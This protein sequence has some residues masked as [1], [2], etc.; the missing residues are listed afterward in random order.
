MS[1]TDA[2]TRLVEA[3]GGSDL[4]EIP[5][6]TSEPRTAAAALSPKYGAVP[7]QTDG[8]VRWGESSGASK[9]IVGSVKGWWAGL[10]FKMKLVVGAVGAAATIAIIAGIAAGAS[11]KSA[12]V[13]DGCT[14]SGY[15]LSGAAVPSAYNI[16]WRTALASGPLDFY[17]ST[18]IDT[19]ITASGQNCVQ[20]HSYELDIAS[21]TIDDGSGSG[22]VPA[23]SWSQ[24]EVNER[25]VVR[26]PRTANTGA[27]LRMQLNYSAPLRVDNSGL[28]LTTYVD[29][30]GN[31]VNA[32]CTQFEATAFRRASPGFDEPAMKVRRLQA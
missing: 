13:E 17:G 5:I 7:T 16:Y 10:T 8:F 21:I 15:R 1:A 18:T 30:L 3:S 20:L 26:L 9:G 24:D 4:T 31:T 6:S 14:Y 28:Y 23:Q 27:R 25:V 22:P 2:G 29:D 11:K 19:T 12:P 32:A